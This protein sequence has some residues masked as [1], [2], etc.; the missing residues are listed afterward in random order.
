M[1]YPFEFAVTEVDKMSVDF[2]SY[3]ATASSMVVTVDALVSMVVI[4]GKQ[5]SALEVV[6]TPSQN[7]DTPVPVYHDMSEGTIVVLTTSLECCQR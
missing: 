2:L 6:V 5:L 4:V 1:S 7:R 3:S